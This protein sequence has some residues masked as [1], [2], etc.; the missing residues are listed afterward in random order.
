MPPLHTARVV[1]EVVSEEYRI[2]DALNHEV[3]V[4]TSADW[5]RL[6]ETRFS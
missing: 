4:S 3:T 5:V 6:F 1:N 2:L